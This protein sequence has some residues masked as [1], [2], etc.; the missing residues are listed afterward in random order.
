MVWWEHNLNYPGPISSIR[1]KNL[2]RGAQ[3][4]EYIHFAK[5]AGFKTEADEIVKKAIP[6]ALSEVEKTENSTWSPRGN[7]WDGYRRE[8]TDLVNQK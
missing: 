7:D 2:R 3:D 5:Q 1:M 6:R 8:L 4:L